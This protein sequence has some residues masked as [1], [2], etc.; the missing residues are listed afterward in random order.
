[1]KTKGV[2]ILLHI[3]RPAKDFLGNQA[4]L[5]EDMEK[6]RAKLISRN[7][8]NVVDGKFVLNNAAIRE[9]DEYGPMPFHAD[10]SR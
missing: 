4:S 10:D 9:E 7:P 1:V 5:S 6:V 8:G 2:R 3:R